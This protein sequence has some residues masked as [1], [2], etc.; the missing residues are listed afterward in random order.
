MAELREQ[1]MI[2]MTRVHGEMKFAD[3]M[4]KRVSTW[5]FRRMFKFMQDFQT[6]VLESDRLFRGSPGRSFWGYT[7]VLRVAVV[8]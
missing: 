5:K 2:K 6:R 4:T 3:L 8:Y 7:G 1:K